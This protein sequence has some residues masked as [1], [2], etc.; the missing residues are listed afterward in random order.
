MTDQ[1]TANAGSPSSPDGIAEQDIET[2]ATIEGP[3][4]CAYTDYNQD[5]PSE[6]S[7]PAT[8]ENATGVEQRVWDRLY[9]ID[10]PEMPVSIVD[11]GLI[12]GVRAVE[13]SEDTTGDA[14]DAA[15]TR[16]AIDMTLTYTGCP[17]RKMLTEEIEAEVRSV[18]G[19]SEVSLDLVWSP[20]WSLSMVTEQGRADLRE[21][22]LSVP[23]GE[24]A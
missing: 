8:G 5:T 14:A 12:Y 11:L 17:A 10:D 6:T 3:E 4:Y 22:G 13:E 7:L 20:N 19:V 1:D 18:E 15:G 24:E 16:V 9:E 21:F 2:E 23:E